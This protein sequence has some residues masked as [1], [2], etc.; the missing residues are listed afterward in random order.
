[1]RKFAILFAAA[2]TL[3]FAAPAVAAGNANAGGP[4]L[5]AQSDAVSHEVGSRHRHW[6]RPRHWHGHG[7]HWHRPVR[8]C[9]TFW[10]HGRRVTVCR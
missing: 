8:H 1:M 6:H 3:G 7:R 5:A 2:A 4:L 10:R 9:N